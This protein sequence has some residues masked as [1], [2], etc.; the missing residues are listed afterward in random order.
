MCYHISF[1]LN[2]ESILDYFP[3]VIIDHQ[4]DV[5]FPTASY[6]N[7]FNH[8]D[9]PV[10]LRSRKDEALH[11][12]KMLWGYLPNGIKNFDEAARFWNGYRDEK[13]NWKKGFVTLNAVGEDILSHRGMW[14]DA[15]LNRRCIVI[16][17]GMFEW[18]HVF[19]IGKK[20]VALKTAIKYPYHI[21][22]KEK[23]APFFMMAGL[24]NAWKHSEVDKD[25]GEL[26]TFYTA[27]FAIVT[28]KANEL[29]AQVHNS[30]ER[31]PT[32][33]N[34]EL[35]HQWLEKDLSEEKIIQLAT[36]QFPANEMMAYTIAKDFQEIQ[37][38]KEEFEYEGLDAVV[39]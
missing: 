11:L 27:T 1:Q 34:K 4:L 9:V 36:N 24:W 5:Q 35:A 13:G 26:Q 28:T 23:K 14:R 8:P 30:K 10:V 32:I 20:G 33:L 31:M 2:L 25:T 3:D 16:A 19:P 38:P 18:R 17:D 15:A 7:G 37:N 22:V 29:M 39:C 12:A 21:H 6:I